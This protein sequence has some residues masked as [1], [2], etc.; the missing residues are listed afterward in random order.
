[1]AKGTKSQK[2][3]TAYWA[4]YKLARL[5]RD[6]LHRNGTRGGLFEYE[7]AELRKL[8]ADYESTLTADDY[9]GCDPSEIFD[10]PIPMPS[11]EPEA[12]DSNDPSL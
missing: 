4:L 11:E 3:E 2:N 6:V 1:M 9:L 5:F 8:K 10:N 12:S 7:A